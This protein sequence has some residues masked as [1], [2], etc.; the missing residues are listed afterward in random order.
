M[1]HTSNLCSKAGQPI[2]NRLKPIQCSPSVALEPA[3][4]TSLDQLTPSRALSEH[5]EALAQALQSPD[6]ILKLCS[7][8]IL[9]PPSWRWQLG[10]RLARGEPVPRRLVDNWTKEA[11]NFVVALRGRQPENHPKELLER[12]PDRYTALQL[13]VHEPPPLRWEVEARILAQEPFEVIGQKTGVRWEAIAWYERWFFNVLDRLTCEA[14][15]VHQV[16]RWYTEHE[17]SLVHRFTSPSV[18]RPRACRCRSSCTV[19]RNVRCSAPSKPA[20]VP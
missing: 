12:M 16:I 4:V 18:M 17:R 2:W 20:V 9:R 5:Q 14:Y 6:S 7:D 19:W 13:Y 3:S 10:V 15:V 1:E 8:G 11:R